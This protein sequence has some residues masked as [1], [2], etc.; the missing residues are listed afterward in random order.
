MGKKN[1]KVRYQIS[2]NE[3]SKLTK[4]LIDPQSYDT[5][6]PSWRFSKLAPLG[7][8]WAIHS[9]NETVKKDI[10]KKLMYF[11]KMT[12]TDIKSSSTHKSHNVNID[13]IIT[14][15]QKELTDLHIYED[16]IFSLRLTGK[17]RIWGI[18]SRGVLE[19][20]WYDSNHEICPSI[21]K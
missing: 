17:E 4:Q 8:K 1:K 12:W 21:K 5:L 3:S 19:I 6:N 16:Q 11:E 7:S 13:K 15:A 10:I 18:L 20:I 9:V 14:S 2:D